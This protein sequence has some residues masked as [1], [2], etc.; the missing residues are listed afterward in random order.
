MQF[1]GTGFS[2]RDIGADAIDEYDGF[3]GI[4]GVMM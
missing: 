1:D 3:D 4:R 2:A